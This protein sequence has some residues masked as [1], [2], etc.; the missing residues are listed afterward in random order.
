MKVGIPLVQQNPNRCVYRLSIPFMEQ[1]GQTSESSTGTS[2]I[3]H[4]APPC[5]AIHSLRFLSTS[6]TLSN[7]DRNLLSAIA[8][9]FLPYSI[10]NL[11]AEVDLV[12]IEAVLRRS[13]ICSKTL[14]VW[15]LL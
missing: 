9:A 1:T 7:S 13:L 2:Q 8:L 11:L 12:Q 3:T 15:R 14:A 10:D 5:L 4:F 6:W